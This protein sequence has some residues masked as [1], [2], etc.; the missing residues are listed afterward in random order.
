MFGQNHFRLVII[1]LSMGVLLLSGCATVP[2]ASTEK[3]STSKQFSPV[4]EKASLYIFRN[5]VL[6]AA[7]PLSVFVNGK[8]LGQTASKTYFHLS[9]LPGEYSIDSTAENVCTLSLELEPGQ[10]YFVWQEMK[11]GMWMARCALH[12]MDEEKGRAGVLES[13][14]IKPQ[15]S[16][17]EVLPA[18]SSSNSVSTKL[19]ALDGLRNDGI[20][21]ED[22]F[23]KKKKD[24][25][26]QL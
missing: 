19:R 8:N 18:G 15:V 12:L 4:P 14:L 26:E 2:M 22:E 10:N 11:M 1:I 13:K 25:L 23:L 5:E 3:D 16:D 17:S 6:G 24:L 9:L 7:I 20:I 21:T